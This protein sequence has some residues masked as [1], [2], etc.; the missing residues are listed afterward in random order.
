MVSNSKTVDE[1]LE[2]LNSDTRFGDERD[3][4]FSDIKAE[5][6]INTKTKAF[7]IYWVYL[8]WKVNKG[9]EPIDRRSFFKGLKSRFK[10][11]NTKRNYYYV[12][13]DSFNLTK[14]EKKLIKQHLKEEKRYYN[15]RR[16]RKKISLWQKRK[17]AKER[18]VKK[19]NQ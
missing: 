9:G 16:R 12:K 3:D 6:D 18:L 1:L 13:S 14:E 8:K 7:I 11:K 17:Y 5:P 15:E 4:F 2:I 10:H 19:Q